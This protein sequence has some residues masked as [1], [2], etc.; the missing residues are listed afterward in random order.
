MDTIIEPEI[1]IKPEIKIKKSKCE[2]VRKWQALNPEKMKLY[3]EKENIKRRE[4]RRLF[5][6]LL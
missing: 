5:R 1:E 6:I 4:K 3:R 2:Q